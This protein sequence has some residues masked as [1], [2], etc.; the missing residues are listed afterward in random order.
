MTKTVVVIGVSGQIGLRS[1]AECS[2]E[3]GGF[4]AS[5]TLIPRFPTTPVDVEVVLGDRKDDAGSS[6]S[7]KT[8]LLRG[9]QNKVT[10]V[11]PLLRFA[12]SRT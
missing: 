10:S 7:T 3:G 9:F 1:P 6:T 8:H 2:R 5:T 4:A 12:S 11:P